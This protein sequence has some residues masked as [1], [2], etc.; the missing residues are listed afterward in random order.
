MNL[1]ITIADLPYRFY[2]ASQPSMF[3]NVRQQE[4][5][6]MNSVRE[7]LQQSHS[8]ARL[9]HLPHKASTVKQSHKKQAW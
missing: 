1:E 2:T 7:L 3:E 8:C 5:M 6:A 4:A 9:R